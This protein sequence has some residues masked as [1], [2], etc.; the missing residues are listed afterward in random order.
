MTDLEQ[1]FRDPVSVPLEDLCFPER[2]DLRFEGFGG[3]AFE[4]L[5]R[6]RARPYLAQY[7]KEKSS[8]RRHLIEPFRRY[9]DD[10]VV[11]F[12]LPSRLAFE[13]ENGV[14]SRLLKN[15]FGAG[16]CHDHLWMSFYRPGRRR[17]TDLQLAHTIGPDGLSVGFF[18]GERMGDLFHRGRARIV[19]D[20]ESFSHLLSPLLQVK[21]QYGSFNGSLEHGKIPEVLERAQFIRIERHFSREYVMQ[22]RGQIVEDVLKA[23]RELWPLYRYFGE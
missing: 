5:E 19:R 7:Q 14:F 10:L 3:E 6:L 23:V 16:G 22:R 8:I 11:A 2:L 21:T 17:L 1:F 18:A 20:P 15:D 9:R 4:I 12:V 13:T